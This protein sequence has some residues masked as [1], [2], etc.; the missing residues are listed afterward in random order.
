MVVVRDAGE[1][2]GHGGFVADGIEVLVEHGL[3]GGET[4]LIGVSS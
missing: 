3:L 4:F 1:I 2:L